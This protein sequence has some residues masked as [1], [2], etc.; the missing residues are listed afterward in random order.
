MKGMA[1]GKQWVLPPLFP[2]CKLNDAAVVNDRHDHQYVL[3]ILTP[4]NPVSQKW[5]VQRVAKALDTIH[6]D[7]SE[8]R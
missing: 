7:M 4:A 8:Y 2:G 1:A 6:M 5:K 3:A